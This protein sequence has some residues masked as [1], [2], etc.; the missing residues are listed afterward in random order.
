MRKCVIAVMIFFLLSITGC[1]AEQEVSDITKDVNSTAALVS[2]ALDTRESKTGSSDAETIL[3]EESKKNAVVSFPYLSEDGKLVIQSLF[4]SSI[5]NPDCGDQDGEN[6]ASIELHNVSEEFLMKASIE[7]LMADGS[8]YHFE[9]ADIPPG[10]SVWAFETQN[11][12]LP[13][14]ATCEKITCVAEFC[15]E[16]NARNE[17]IQAKADGTIVTVI[18]QTDDI[19]TG[20]TLNFHCLFDE[21]MYFGGTVYSYSIE[22]LPVGNAVELDVSECYMGSAELVSTIQNDN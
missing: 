6:I 13:K 4:Q 20:Y 10:K 15:E 18:N 9:I 5:S 16:Q 3:S 7:L 12:E 11:A 22:E 2:T 8:A 14:E 17:K 21:D 1:K 19:L